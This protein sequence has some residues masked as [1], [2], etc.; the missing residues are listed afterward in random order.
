MVFP[1]GPRTLGPN[2]A[3]RSELR[4][5]GNGPR[6]RAFASL[7]RAG[8]PNLPGALAAWS[9]QTGPRLA[10]LLRSPTGH[11]PSQRAIASALPI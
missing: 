7:M 5:P 4:R 10:P 6:R 9:P 3:K 8:G 11:A 2:L 1:G